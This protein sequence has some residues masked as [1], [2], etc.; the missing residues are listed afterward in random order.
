M[1]SQLPP[2]WLNCGHRLLGL[3]PPP[4]GWGREWGEAWPQRHPTPHPSFP[5]LSP[6]SPPGMK[7]WDV[8]PAS[9]HF[10]GLASSLPLPMR[11]PHISPPDS[12]LLPLRLLNTDE[13][14]CL[15]STPFMMCPAGTVQISYIWCSIRKVY[16]YHHFPSKQLKAPWMTCL[17]R[18]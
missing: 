7:K 3:A 16:D 5:L 4:Q 2:C 15:S 12:Q 10:I 1:P 8:S 13:K 9:H 6:L 14:Y 17:R 11:L 18:N